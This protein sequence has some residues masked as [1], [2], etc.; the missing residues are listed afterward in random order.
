MIS[1]P[2]GFAGYAYKT[3]DLTEEE[4]TEKEGSG[5]PLSPLRAQPTPKRLLLYPTF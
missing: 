4:K 5:V 1:W 2:H 3:T